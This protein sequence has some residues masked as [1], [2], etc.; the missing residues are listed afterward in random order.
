MSRQKSFLLAMGSLVF[1]LTFLLG[2]GS[3]PDSP[4][5]P[6]TNLCGE[7]VTSTQAIESGDNYYPENEGKSGGEVEKLIFKLRLCHVSR[8]DVSPLTVSF[9]S[10]MAGGQAP[11]TYVWDFGNEAVSTEAAPTY[12][13]DAAGDYLVRLMAQDALG[14]S[15]VESVGVF[16]SLD[17]VLGDVMGGL[18]KIT[19]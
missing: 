5:S 7:V 4:A 18:P 3:M 16:L 13:Y 15:L 11:Y 8:T 10:H 19:P 1:S 17:G 6:D 14:V 2:C 12:T 9:W